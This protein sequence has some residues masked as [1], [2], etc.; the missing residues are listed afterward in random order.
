VT[1]K[2][3]KVFFTTLGV[4]HIMHHGEAVF[5]LRWDIVYV[6]ISSLEGV[7][8]WALRQ[9]SWMSEKLSKDAEDYEV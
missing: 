7:P 4:K 2:T 3:V 8:G 5:S 6:C 9:S 1:L